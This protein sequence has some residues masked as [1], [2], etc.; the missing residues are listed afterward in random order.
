MYPEFQKAFEHAGNSFTIEELHFAAKNMFLPKK[1]KKNKIT[2]KYNLE[3]QSTTKLSKKQ[4]TDYIRHI[5]QYSIDR[6]EYAMDIKDDE[7]LLF[8]DKIIN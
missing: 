3:S 5:E 7:D 2:G 8:Y 6:L 1:R 4:F